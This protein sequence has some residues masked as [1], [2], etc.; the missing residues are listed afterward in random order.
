MHVYYVL[1]RVYIKILFYFHK[2]GYVEN[3]IKIKRVIEQNEEDKM[4]R[5][6]VI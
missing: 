2:I 3:L 5:D 6:R 1:A 4:D